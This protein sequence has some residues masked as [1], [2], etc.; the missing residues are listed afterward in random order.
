MYQTELL[1]LL[2]IESSV[3]VHQEIK[4]EVRVAYLFVVHGRSLRQ[5]KRHLKWL[6]KSS[7]Y[8]FFHVDSRSTY[9][10]REIK[11]LAR[12]SPKNIKVTSNRYATIWG[13]AS[14]LKMMMSCMSEMRKMQWQ[15][16]FII[17]IS[18]S[19]YILK[20]PAEFK[21]FLAKS[22]GKNFVKS[23]GTN[24]A[25]FVKKQGKVEGIDLELHIF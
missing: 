17:N 23:H 4:D 8:F 12:Q 10:Y 24:T 7:D 25:S 2:P 9:L 14:L 20:K 19:D 15:M 22:R 11:E 1:F 21:A 5:I 18:E 16:D 6:Y 13:G 3:E